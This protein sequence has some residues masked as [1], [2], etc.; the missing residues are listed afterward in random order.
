MYLS[1]FL[2][3]LFIIKSQFSLQDIITNYNCVILHVYEDPDEI[4][5]SLWFD[6]QVKDLV[7]SST[8]FVQYKLCKTIFF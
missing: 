8:V 1:I 3:F 2:K 4:Y 7:Q 5:V 6:I